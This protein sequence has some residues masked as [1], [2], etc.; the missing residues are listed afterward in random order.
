[1]GENRLLL[2]GQE[3]IVV[4]LRNFLDIVY[5]FA[6]RNHI[7]LVLKHG[8]ETGQAATPSCKLSKMRRLNKDFLVLI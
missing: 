7:L 1:M 2:D 5:F 4:E 6:Y 8:Y 3:V